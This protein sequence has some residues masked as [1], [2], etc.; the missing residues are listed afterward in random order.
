M[1]G[2]ASA[3]PDATGTTETVVAYF[4]RD[5]SFTGEFGHLGAVAVRSN[6]SGSQL[7]NLSADLG[8]TP[9]ADL[10]AR[11]LNGDGAAE[12]AVIGGVGAHSSLLR[13][14]KWNGAGY[15]LVEEFFG[16][17]G[18]RLSDLDGDGIDEV[19]VGIRHYD[20]AQTREDTI[21]RW[22]G[23]SYTPTQTR[24][25]FTFEDPAFRDYPEAAVLQYYLSIQQHDY[26][27]AWDLLGPGMRSGQS[28]E[29]FV[30][31][32]ATTQDVR[33]EDLEV[34]R[35]D[36]ASAT[37]RVEISSLERD[38]STNRYAG[39]WIGDRAAAGWRLGGAYITPA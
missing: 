25:G 8:E 9:Y 3:P 27:A 33:V 20:R 28:F 29:S 2:T 36:A 37:V 34:T 18:V 7:F 15:G 32:F 17:S 39:T 26:R 19:I 22:T 14:F 30:Q 10:T 11:D 23:T 24:W 21:M 12:L 35:E 13:I 31:G 4:V 1:I 38:G 5:P 16:D 6:T